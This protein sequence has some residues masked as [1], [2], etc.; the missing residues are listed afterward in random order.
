[1]DQYDPDELRWQVARIERKLRQFGRLVLPVLRRLLV[2]AVRLV[3][4]IR[5]RLVAP[6]YRV[7]RGIS[8]AVPRDLSGLSDESSPPP[9]NSRQ[10]ALAMLCEAG[11]LN[12][13][14]RHG[15]IFM[16]SGDL[17][18]AHRLIVAWPRTESDKAP[19]V[20][21]ARSTIDGVFEEMS[22]SYRCDCCYDELRARLV[23]R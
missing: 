1:M 19:D 10:V 23:G 9:K 15:R 17:A 12:Q 20:H 2:R 5:R 16:G 21:T 7:A 22:R 14:L 11:T 13:C 18:A 3:F 8:T 6:A 4:G